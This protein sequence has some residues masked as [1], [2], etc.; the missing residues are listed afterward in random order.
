MQTITRLSRRG[1]VVIPNEI[2]EAMGLE[3]GDLLAIDVLEKV[4][5]RT[6]SKERR[7]NEGEIE[8]DKGQ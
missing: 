6:D 4:P 5:K 7:K 8:Q 2:R 1:Q 3:F